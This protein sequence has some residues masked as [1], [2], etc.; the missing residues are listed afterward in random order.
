MTLTDAQNATLKAHILAT[1]ELNAFPNTEDGAAGIANL[2]N[3]QADPDFTVWKTNVL[4]DEVGK[5][6]VIGISGL[7][8]AE[9]IRIDLLASYSQTG[10]DPSDLQIR[11]LYEN[12]LG[13][14]AD[15]NTAKAN[16]DALWRRLA[17]EIEKLFATGTGSDAV[18][19]TLDFEGNISRQDVQIARNS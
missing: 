4:L 7:T 11:T 6:I 9:S 14:G 18:P 2:L 15:A 3:L 10:V 8:T 5:A 1:P 16:L 13:A 12:E 17:N 19:A